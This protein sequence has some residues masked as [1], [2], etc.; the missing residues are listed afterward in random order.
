MFIVSKIQ[1]KK[2]IGMTFSVGDLLDS[3]VTSV[4][5]LHNIRIV[6]C[7]ESKI[8]RKPS[9]YVLVRFFVGPVIGHYSIS[10]SVISTVPLLK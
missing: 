3:T 7:D 5:P 1:L 6:I 9:G 2:N 8:I 10:K 4:S